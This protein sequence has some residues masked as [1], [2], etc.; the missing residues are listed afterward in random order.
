MPDMSER[1]SLPAI[2]DAVEIT[3]PFS[4]LGLPPAMV[5][6]LAKQGITH[7]FA[8]QAATIPDA[9]SGYDILGRASTGSGKTLAFGI[10]LLARIS[11]MHSEP[12][13]P[14]ALILVPTRELAMQVSE[15]LA[16][17]PTPLDVALSPS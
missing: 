8:I 5:A 2:D 7:A 1:S 4:E 10:P 9:L 16:P 6:V 11:W 3:I 14:R 13:K 15:G 17:L 12:N